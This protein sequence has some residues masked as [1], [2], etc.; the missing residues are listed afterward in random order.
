MAGFFIPELDMDRLTQNLWHSI[1]QLPHLPFVTDTELE[2]NLDLQIVQALR[3]L[4][5]LNLA[6]SICSQCGGQCCRDMGCDLFTA[7][8]GCCPIADYRPLLCRFHYCEKFGLEHET[9]IKWLRDLFGAATSLGEAGSRA[10]VALELNLLLLR[11]CRGADDPCPQLLWDMRQI[12]A[13]ACSGEI[14]WQQ[15]KEQLNQ[16]V[17]VYR[18]NSGPKN[19][20]YKLK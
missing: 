8:L 11:T 20:P 17:E 3:L 5:G 12:T 2:D 4:D 18:S 16:Q 9:L 10:V 14:S 6:Q 1:E 15:A 13:A 7:E 19:N